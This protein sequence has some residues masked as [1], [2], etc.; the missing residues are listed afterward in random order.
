[1]RRHAAAQLDARRRG[2]APPRVQYVP[3]PPPAPRAPRALLDFQAAI[4]GAR[5]RLAG[6]RRPPPPQRFINLRCPAGARPGMNVE[7]TDPDPRGRGQRYSVV[8]PAGVAVGQ[9]FRVPLPGF[10]Q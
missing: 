2:V 9:E 3:M 8:V 7:F 5:A 10:M 1:M 4:A 6:Q